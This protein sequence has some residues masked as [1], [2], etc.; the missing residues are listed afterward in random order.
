MNKSIIF[1]TIFVALLFV[2][3]ENKQV[4]IEESKTDAI[5]V[6]STNKDLSSKQEPDSARKPVFVW[7]HFL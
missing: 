4:N 2:A 6:N 7:I 3:C 1:I 5:V